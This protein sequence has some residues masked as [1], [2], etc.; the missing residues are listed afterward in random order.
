MYARN[1]PDRISV[2]DGRRIAYTAARQKRNIHDCMTC[3]GH[4][5]WAM[6]MGMM[7]YLI[8]Y[9]VHIGLTNSKKKYRTSHRTEQLCNFVLLIY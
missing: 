8:S 7:R 2:N 9:K 1:N 4:W 6:P 5:A 3:H